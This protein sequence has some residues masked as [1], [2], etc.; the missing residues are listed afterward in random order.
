VRAEG[1]RPAVGPAVAAAAVAAAIV[2]LVVREPAWLRLAAKP[3]PALLLAAWVAS[4]N[5]G[6][7]GR[8]VAV[9]LVLSAAGDALLD[10][11]HFL[12]GLLAFLAA[13]LVYLAAFVVSDARPV[14]L[15]ALPFTAWGASVFAVL[16]PGLGPLAAPV[17]AYVTVICAM[18]W[19]ASARI[20]GRTP[21]RLAWLGLAGAVAFA[22]S[23]TIIAFD[24]FA[25]PIASVRLPVMTL[26][27]LG[28][29]SIAASVALPRRPGNDM[30]R[31]R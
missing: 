19:R 2:Y 25:A 6:L 4:R 10:L 15:R 8:L 29:W 24:R 31:G 17:A 11:G 28:Q 20:G 13:H 1:R 14:L 23:D 22:A 16:R 5:R 30:L 18:M 7:E 12:P 27:W 26:Y 9:G 21:A 3:L